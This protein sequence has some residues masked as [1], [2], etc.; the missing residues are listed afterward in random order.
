MSE[1]KSVTDL[2]LRPAYAATRAH[3][4]IVAVLFALAAIG[5]WWTVVEMRGMD[6]GPWTA[7]GTF[8]WFLGVWVV[9]M[10]AMMFPSVA[11][12]V[13][14]YD[15]LRAGHRA[16]GKGAAPD[17]T[18]LFV[19]GYLCVWTGAG[20]AAY[21]LFELVRALDPAFLAW[22]EAGRY[23]T[24]GVIVAA[25]V[26]QLTPLKQACLMKCRSPMMFLAERWRH[27]RA[28]GL[29]LGLRHGEAGERAGGV[30]L[31]AQR[32]VEPLDLPCRGR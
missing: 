9:M 30:E 29:E 24:G 23:L 1:A 14:M 16:R 31:R 26:Y 7:L 25:A 6:D 10:A 21:G 5:W 28:G 27:G 18:A 13:L 11:P 19:A 3:L 17:A 15:R 4:G 20:L 8:G 32:P 12:T 22:D 2:S